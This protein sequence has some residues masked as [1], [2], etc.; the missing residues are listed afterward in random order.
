MA[1]PVRAGRLT[2]RPERPLACSLTHQIRSGVAI[3]FS[4]LVLA[5]MSA[6]KRT[7]Q[8]VRSPSMSAEQSP[9]DEDEKRAKQRKIEEIRSSLRRAQETNQN[10]WQ[11]EVHAQVPRPL[12]HYTTA[13]GLNGMLDSHAIWASDVR[14]M[15]DASEMSYAASLVDEEINSVIASSA[16]SRMQEALEAA[17]SSF[18]IFQFGGLRPFCA[19]FCEKGDLLSQWRGYAAGQIGYSLG[20]DLSLPLITTGLPPRTVLRKVIYN[21][22]EQ[23]SWVRR[24][25]DSWLSG[26]SALLDSGEDPISVNELLPYPG[27]WALQE[28]LIEQYL[29]FKNPGF[30]EEKEWRLIKLV[31][32]REELALVDRLRVEVQIERANKQWEQQGIH[33]PP[34]PSRWPQTNAEGIE[35]RFRPS[36]LGFIPY[37]NLNLNH[38]A[39]VFAGRLPL[40][41]VIQG[42]TSN[43]E[44][45]FDS[46]VM[47]L[48]SRGFA[49]PLTKVS[50]SRIPL[51]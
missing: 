43:T 7:A 42:P 16:D 44:I 36:S 37:I 29:C 48:M 34:R 32:I 18:N 13:S 51:R 25:T 4:M 5:V 28:A 6:T 19:C 14:Y 33:I 3:V 38:R 23:R 47:L 17:R 8:E 12:W 49:F 26:M 31:D 21:E 35:I 40:E 15:N 45:S 41:E 24:I 1:L 39:G 46:L 9:Q 27:I 30:S 11:T 50:Y 20:L 2:A 22:G 10:L